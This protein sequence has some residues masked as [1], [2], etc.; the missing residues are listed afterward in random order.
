MKTPGGRVPAKRSMYFRL[1]GRSEQS[2]WSLMWT[3]I[4]LCSRL[5]GMQCKVMISVETASLRGFWVI[6]WKNGFV[7]FPHGHFKWFLGVRSHKPLEVTKWKH[8]EIYLKLPSIL[9]CLLAC[10]LVSTVCYLSLCE[11]RNYDCHG[12]CLPSSLSGCSFFL[13]FPYLTR[14]DSR[15]FALLKIALANLLPIDESEQLK[16]HILL[17]HLKLRTACHLALAYAHHPLPYTKAM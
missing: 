1:H 17:D 8:V 5:W 2:T 12:S 6:R 15:Q 9:L 16:C 7:L 11:K 13:S 10:H 14:D 3:K 4:A